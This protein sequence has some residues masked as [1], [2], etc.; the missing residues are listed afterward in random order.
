[1]KKRNLASVMLLLLILQH[2]NLQGQTITGNYLVIN[3]T[4]G[5]GTALGSGLELG[6]LGSTT[7]NFSRLIFHMVR[8][9]AGAD[10]TSASTRITMQ[11]DVTNQ[12]YI[13]FNPKGGAYGIS[14]GTYQ[15]GNAINI[16]SSSAVGMG[17]WD[18]RGYKLAVAG[19]ILTDKVKVAVP[20]TAQW[21]DYVFAKEYKLM[22]LEQVEQFIKQ[23]NHLPDVPSAAEMVKQGNDLG[24]TDVLLLE[25]IEQ[26]TLYMIE[27][28]KQNDR[29]QTEIQ[30]LRSKLNLLHQ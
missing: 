4:P 7:S 24:K 13:D 19:G 22:P 6:R 14:L 15:G 12:G 17:T 2:C 21:A 8:H 9:T 5:L 29:Q 27:L 23:H 16:N 28:K 25:K 18:T 10:W 30:N 1:M 11:T 20:G 26:L 3:K